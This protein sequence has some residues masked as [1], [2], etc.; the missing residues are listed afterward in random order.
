MGYAIDANDKNE[1]VG[2]A[3]HLFHKYLDIPRLQVYV[4]ILILLLNFL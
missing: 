4:C 1:E 3:L 2:T